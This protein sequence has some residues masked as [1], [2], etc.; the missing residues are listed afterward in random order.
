MRNILLEAGAIGIILLLIFI[1]LHATM[2]AMNKKFS[3][4][5]SGVFLGVFLA[6]ALG[7]LAFEVTG[8]NAAFCKKFQEGL[9]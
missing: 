1:I 5:H 7:H 6:G 4:S 3:M 2:M 8:Q 9:S